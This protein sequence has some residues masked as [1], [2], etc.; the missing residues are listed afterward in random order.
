[1]ADSAFGQQIAL[2]IE[3]AKELID[4]QLEVYLKSEEP[5]LK[6]LHESIRY[7]LNSGG[8]RI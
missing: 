1:M 5:L 6:R 8:K 4:R 3:Q 7:S 2:E